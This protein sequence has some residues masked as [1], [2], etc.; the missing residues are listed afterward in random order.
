MIHRECPQQNESNVQFDMSVY[1]NLSKE[2]SCVF[3]T[4]FENS[5]G[6]PFGS[7]IWTSTATYGIVIGDEDC[8]DKGYGTE[9]T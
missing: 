3:F 2:S 8:R 6:R 7:H 9:T 5:S 4:I 1:Y